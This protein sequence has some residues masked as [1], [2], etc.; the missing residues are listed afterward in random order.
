MFL[1]NPLIR[2]TSKGQMTIPQKVREALGLK[3]GDYLSVL[4]D[5]EEI[6][7]R[8]VQQIRP[9]SNDDP[10]WNIVGAGNSGRQDVA[11]RHDHY[12]AE[13][14]AERWQK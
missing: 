11:A 10:I 13:G 9:L 6:R 1:Y 4:V 12:L 3:A 8:K 2:L 7:L 14:E 5:K